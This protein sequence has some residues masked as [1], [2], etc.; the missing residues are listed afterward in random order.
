MLDKIKGGLYLVVDPKPGMSILDRVKSALRGGVDIIQL[1][2]NWN[3]DDQRSEIILQVCAMAHQHHVP[4]LINENWQLLNDFPLDGVHFDL[5]PKDWSDIKEKINKPFIAGIT[6]G[7]EEEKITWAI[8]NNLDYISFC[9]MFPSSTA[10]HCDLVE[11]DIIKQTRQKSDIP[12]FVSGGITP[13][14][15]FSVMVLGVSGVAVLSG[16]LK[17][18]N[19]ETAAREFKR[20]LQ[21]N[22]T[23]VI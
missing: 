2:N 12:I 1:W 22:T 4:V 10:N 14:N 15:I 13:E 6:C 9:S 3:T 17:T 19:S 20:S 23:Y 5:I 21:N 16:I 8:N 7:N 11:P 18:E